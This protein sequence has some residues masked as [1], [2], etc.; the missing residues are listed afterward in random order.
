MILLCIKIF[1]ARIV[2]VTL[3]TIRTVLVV[4]SRRF[5]PAIIAFF[6]VL[7]WFVVAREALTTS[8]KSIA[9]PVFYAL[10]YATGTFIGGFISNNFV[11]GLIGVQ[12]ITDKL[13]VNEMISKMRDSGFGVSAIDLKYT[14]NNEKKCM[15]IIQLNKAKLKSLTKIIRTIDEK[16]FVAINETRY[17]QNGVIK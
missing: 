11:S 4:K 8:V 3:G 12:V 10:G 14:K 17:I 9:I 1:L 6:E 13:Y 16:A 5:T 7:I 2:D 15:L